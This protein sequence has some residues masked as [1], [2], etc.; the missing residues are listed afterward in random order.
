MG[1]SAKQK[2]YNYICFKAVVGEAR[3]VQRMLKIA[4]QEG[5]LPRRNY[6]EKD[7]DFESVRET[8]W[9]KNLLRKM[10]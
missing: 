4:I 10:P 9:F 7:P 3:V 2:P 1:E 5:T 6:I 8:R